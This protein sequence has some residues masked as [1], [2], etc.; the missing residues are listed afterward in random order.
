M[1]FFAWESVWSWLRQYD[2]LHLKIVV[3]FIQDCDKIMQTSL[4]GSY[5]AYS[6]VDKGHA[7]S[8]S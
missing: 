5:D 6:A 1:V 8:Q 3:L 7:E 4:G 2:C